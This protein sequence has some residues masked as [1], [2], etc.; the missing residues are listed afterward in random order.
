[1]MVTSRS[2]VADDGGA[3]RVYEM[4]PCPTCGEPD[5]EQ[6]EWNRM[7]AKITALEEENA[8]LEEVITRCDQDISEWIS[9]AMEAEAAL[10]QE[11]EA[12]QAFMKSAAKALAEERALADDL[13][14]LLR[15]IESD[16]GLTFRDAPRAILERWRSQRETDD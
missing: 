11:R 5:Y 13:G 9:R 12:L 3:E 10:A 7:V 1:M 8:R 16:L 4:P 15:E 14:G 2:E 6:A